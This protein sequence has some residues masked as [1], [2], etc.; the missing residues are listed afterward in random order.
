MYLLAF[1]TWYVVDGSID[2]KTCEEVKGRRGPGISG[3]RHLSHQYNSLYGYQIIDSILNPNC[4][5][6]V[7]LGISWSHGIVLA[8]IA[9]LVLAI[10]EAIHR[11]AIL[12]GLSIQQVQI[13]L[14][15]HSE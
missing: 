13:G 7:G 6:L 3:W 11:T 8:H 2:E 1:G 10:C 4:S 12:G 9:Y 15:C 5:L 14:P